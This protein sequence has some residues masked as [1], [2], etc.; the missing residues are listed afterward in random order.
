MRAAPPPG[1]LRS[2]PVLK[3]T[4][5]ISLELHLKPA[6]GVRFRNAERC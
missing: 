1:K 2:V 6:H 4:V 3:A 5:T